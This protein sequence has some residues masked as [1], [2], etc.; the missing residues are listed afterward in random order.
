MKVLY[1]RVSTT[2]QNI[3]RQVIDKD[4]YDYVLIDKCSGSIPLFERP[5]GSE[6]EK[7]GD[8]WEGSRSYYAFMLL[9]S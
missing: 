9:W 7:L 1:T 8:E 5:N 2:E 6:I 3:D 4:K